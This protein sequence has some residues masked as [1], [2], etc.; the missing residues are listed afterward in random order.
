[1]KDGRLTALICMTAIILCGSCHPAPLVTHAKPVTAI[2]GAFER[3][4]TL[5]EDQL[6]DPQ[7]KNIEGI[8][9]ATGK[10]KG[11]EVVVVWTGIGKVNAAMTTTL[12]I[13]HF[14]PKHIIFTGIAG[15]VNPELEPGDIV[16]AERTA[17]HDMGTVWPEG[18]FFR[19]V[20]SPLDGFENPVFFHAD[21][22]LVEVA[23]RAAQQI[24][25]GQIR[26]LTGE[27][28]PRI[29]TGVVVTGD[30]FI[31][32]TEKCKELRKRLEA[33][34]VEMEGAAVAQICY[35]RQI[36]HIVIRS[37]SDNAD[38]GAVLDKQ[39]FYIMAVRN[40]AALVAEIVGLMAS[41]PTVEKNDGSDNLGN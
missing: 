22:E 30:A 9:F 2:L 33:D 21:E 5:L 6:S 41:D 19:G 40:S 18:L 12:L 24:N 16:I 25:L 32:S 36:S 26:L 39:T 13:E 3:E 37:I 34:A 29:I 28:T 8:G 23:Q 35:Q 4:V 10:L 14:K 1:M 20:K 7:E 27:R 11:Q 15:A 17:H 31:A 38:E